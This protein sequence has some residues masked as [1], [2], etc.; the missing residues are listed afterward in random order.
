MVILFNFWGKKWA[1]FYYIGSPNK[2]TL[3]WKRN[4]YSSGKYFSNN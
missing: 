2:I 3:T 1:D 4:I